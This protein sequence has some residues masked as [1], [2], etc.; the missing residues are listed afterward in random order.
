MWY[1]KF[2]GLPP[3]GSLL[4]SLFTLVYLQRKEAELLSTRALVQVAMPDEREAQDPAIE[5]FQKYCDQMFPFLERATNK[6]KEEARKRLAEF[7]K[8]PAKIKLKPIWKM[9]A[10][11]AKRM[12]TLK[13]FA[14]NPTV[15]GAPQTY[16]LGAKK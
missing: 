15:P 11:H 14:I 4:E 16:S 6:D 8:K 13:R 2:Q 7:V 1:D 3:R 12:A 10:Q 9:Q 5:A